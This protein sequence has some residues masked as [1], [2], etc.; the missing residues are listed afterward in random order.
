MVILAKDRG[1]K[2]YELTDERFVLFEELPFDGSSFDFSAIKLGGRM[3]DRI[4]H[5]FFERY[6]LR[7]VDLS[8]DLMV[9]NHWCQERY[10]RRGEQWIPCTENRQHVLRFLMQ[11]VLVSSPIARRSTF[12][13]YRRLLDDE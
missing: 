10:D 9:A 13:L 3:K 5:A 11:W 1:L 8:T 6:R 4:D 12:D 2:H 7:H